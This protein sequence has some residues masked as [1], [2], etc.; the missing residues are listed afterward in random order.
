VIR[1]RVG[2]AGGTTK[3][4]TYERIGDH[5]ETTQIEFDPAVISYE[6][7]LEIFWESHDPTERPYS[8]QYAAILF[9]H[10]ERQAKAAV[11]SRDR[12]AARL[13]RSIHTEIRP[14]AAFTR[15]ED[16]HQKYY[17]RR[18]GELARQIASA[19]PDFVD[20]TASARANGFLGG[21]GRAAEFEAELPSLKL[22]DALAER[23]RALLREQER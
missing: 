5:T 15:A 23:L 22:P 10:D 7:L 6:K 4:P 8:R 9:T 12:L 17:L 20:A 21:W 11:A 13:K 2:Y 18:R 16:Y 19:V 3:N 14:A 1:T